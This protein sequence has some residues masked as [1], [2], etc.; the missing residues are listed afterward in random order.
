MFGY[1]TDETEELM[2]LTLQLAHKLNH[3][4]EECRQNGR[5]PW[6]RPDCKSQV[7]K[8]SFVSEDMYMWFS[9]NGRCNG[10]IVFSV[11]SSLDLKL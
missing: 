11:C 9:Q 3:K 6:V 4:L 10:L 2:P 8:H 5:L 1:A 7:Q